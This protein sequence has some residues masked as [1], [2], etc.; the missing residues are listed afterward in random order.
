MSNTSLSQ[1]SLEVFCEETASGKPTPG[2]GSVSSLIGALAASLSEM[3]A[4]L[5]NKKRHLETIQPELPAYI[6]QTCQIRLILLQSIQQDSSAFNKFMEAINLPKNT[7][8]EK[9]FRIESMQKA[10]KEACEIPL[11]VAEIS[12]SLFPIIC[13]LAQYGNPNAITDILVAAM[14]TRV[15]ISGALLNVN[16]NL[17][18]I[19]DSAYRQRISARAQELEQNSSLM[20][21]KI[22][23]YGYSQLTLENTKC[24]KS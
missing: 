9:Q 7:V 5:S 22:L 20:E 11:S 17:R 18:S 10:L 16:I 4:H 23:S 14:A 12:Y 1:L 2:G 21:Q 15:A 19:K 13:K 6:E 8:E 3:V 24:Q